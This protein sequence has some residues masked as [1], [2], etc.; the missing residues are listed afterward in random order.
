MD[1]VDRNKCHFCYPTS[2]ILFGFFLVYV[3]FFCACP[4]LSTSLPP[5]PTAE[6]K[7]HCSVCQSLD[8]LPV[9]YFFMKSHTDPTASHGNDTTNKNRNRKNGIQMQIAFVLLLILSGDVELNPGPISTALKFAQFN[10]QSISPTLKHD[11]PLEIQQFISDNNI[12]IL[13]ISE[14]WL[15]PDSLPATINSLLLDGYSFEHQPRPSGRGGGVGYIYRSSLKFSKII[16]QTYQSFELITCKLTCS[17]SS[18]IFAHI[19]RPPSSS[20]CLFLD[21]FSTL[22]EDLAT[23][24]S[25]L[26]IS[27]DFNIHL[28]DHKDKVSNS[29]TELISSFGLKQFISFPT[30]NHGHILDLLLARTESNTQITCTSSI[31][32]FSD[33]FAVTSDIP[34]LEAT[35]NSST[36]KTVRTFKNFSVSGFCDTVRSSGLNSIIDIPLELYVNVFSATISNILDKF[37]PIIK[38]STST[39]TNQ[40]FYNKEIRDQKRIRS[41]LESKWRKTKNHE[42]RL[43]YKSQANYVAKLVKTAKQHYY[44]NAIMKNSSCPQKLW[45]LV[46]K[47][48]CKTNSSPLPDSVSDTHLANSFSDFFLLR[49]ENSAPNSPPLHL[50]YRLHMQSH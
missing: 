3:F 38:I 48:W 36:F 1:S 50:T 40:P 22:L 35:R 6:V 27:G 2:C 5:F 34:L 49:S 21:E 32:S 20:T 30:H 10:A 41:R 23:V 25:E 4:Y 28:D 8:T 7:P 45:S 12:D 26:Y 16:S 29:F 44:R 43:A 39:K 31:L 19:Y 11:K 15:K 18:Y 9:G 14:T 47:V 46:N 13:A 42:S 37:A 33:H 24:P 17:A